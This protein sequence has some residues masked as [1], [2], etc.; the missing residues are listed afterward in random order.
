M[1]LAIGVFPFVGTQPLQSIHYAIF[2]A[3][4]VNIFATSLEQGSYERLPSD[5]LP[6]LAG[7]VR[8]FRHWCH[9]PTYWLAAEQTGIG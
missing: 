4:N 1:Y 8:N 7:Q 2:L 3:Q 6:P 5:P 9:K